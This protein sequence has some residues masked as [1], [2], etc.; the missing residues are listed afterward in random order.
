M[1][2]FSNTMPLVPLTRMTG[3]RNGVIVRA[4]QSN[5]RGRVAEEEPPRALPLRIWELRRCSAEDWYCF[6]FCR[7]TILF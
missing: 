1:A 5:G 7:F 2:V 4:Q 3:L 6:S